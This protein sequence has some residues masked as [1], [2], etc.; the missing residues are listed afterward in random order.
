M[1]LGSILGV[2]TYRDTTTL[3]QGVLGKTWQTNFTTFDMWVLSIAL[4]VTMLF[5]FVQIFITF[6]RG[7]KAWRWQMGLLAIGFDVLVF[8]GLIVGQIKLR[9]I[10]LDIKAPRAVVIE[11]INSVLA[12]VNWKTYNPEYS[13]VFWGYE[14]NHLDM[15]SVG[16]GGSV[17]SREHEVLLNVE[18]GRTIYL[19]IL[20]GDEVYGTN[21]NRSGK[22]YAVEGVK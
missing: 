21:V 18:P 6:S 10:M 3:V 16:L 19:W 8:V 22:P 4:I 12:S 14:P 13:I 17:K 7:K 5:I 11:R 15:S 2:E 9:Y 20:V 1:H